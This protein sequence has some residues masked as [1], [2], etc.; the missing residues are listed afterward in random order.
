MRE[1]W[2]R[3][4][5]WNE[6]IA[7]RFNEK[8]RR[9]RR[10]E[11]YLRIQALSLATTHPEVIEAV[12]NGLVKAGVDPARIVV[13][14]RSDKDMATA[15]LTINREGKGVRIYG[16]EGRW[17]TGTKKCSLEACFFV[18]MYLTNR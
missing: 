12:T 13:Y 2:Y 17:A 11:Q 5:N 14:D 9:A 18:C 15:R 7:R 6:A 16:T 4:K 3:N 8:L 1:D 10:K